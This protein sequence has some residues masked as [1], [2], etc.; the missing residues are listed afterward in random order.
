M[1]MRCELCYVMDLGI[2]RGIT[3]IEI[4]LEVLEVMFAAE[5]ERC[6]KLET[7]LRDILRDIAEYERVN[8]LTPNPG[9]AYCWDS[10]ER[11]YAAIRRGDE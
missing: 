8:N 7:A 4:S 6:A 1:K 9:R 2:L 5:R 3:D 10:I 11:A